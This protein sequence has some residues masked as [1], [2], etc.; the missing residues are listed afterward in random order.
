ME[1]MFQLIRKSFLLFLAMAGCNAY[2]QYRTYR[3]VDNGIET[4]GYCKLANGQVTHKFTSLPEG[5]TPISES[6]NGSYSI[7]IPEYSNTEEH[8]TVGDGVSFEQVFNGINAR[9]C[10]RQGYLNFQEA[11]RE[12][13]KLSYSRKIKAII[14]Y[15]DNAIKALVKD[16]RSGAI[17]KVKQLS[18][19][20]NE[21]PFMKGKPNKGY[22]P[23]Y[24]RKTENAMKAILVFDPEVNPDYN[25][26]VHKSN[27]EET[28]EKNKKRR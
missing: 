24:V 6:E 21:V 9:Y 11:L 1:T 16:E 14:G 23:E 22:L 27:P 26:V 8:F 25:V 18:D 3:V 20:T 12:K 17:E 15:Y 7:E 2:A 28:A 4:I 10:V 13:D 5:G 19:F